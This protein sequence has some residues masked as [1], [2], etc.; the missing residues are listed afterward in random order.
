MRKILIGGLVFLLALTAGAGAVY[1]WPVPTVQEACGAPNWC[2]EIGSFYDFSVHGAG[3][4]TLFSLMVDEPG[5]LAWDTLTFFGQRRLGPH[6]LVAA[7]YVTMHTPARNFASPMLIYP[8]A[9]GNVMVAFRITTQRNGNSFA[10][11]DLY[12]HRQ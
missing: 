10:I 6:A 3:P 9:Q 1:F 11:V 7:A 8:T 5:W 12:S 4:D 2:K